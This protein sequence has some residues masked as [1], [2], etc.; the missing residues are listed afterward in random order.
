M[1]LIRGLEADTKA[2]LGLLPFVSIKSSFASESHVH[3]IIS[4]EGVRNC[5]VSIIILDK[6]KLRMASLTV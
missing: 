1:A 4:G 6:E 3:V 5:F 2:N